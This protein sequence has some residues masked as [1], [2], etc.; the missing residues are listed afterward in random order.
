MRGRSVVTGTHEAGSRKEQKVDL[1]AG[2]QTWF[3]K[4]VN[5]G[6]GRNSHGVFPSFA[7]PFLGLCHCHPL[8]IWVFLHDET[9]RTLPHPVFIW[10]G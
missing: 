5:S 8:L 6:H 10:T 4:E 2:S 1:K 7:K 9:L 3:S